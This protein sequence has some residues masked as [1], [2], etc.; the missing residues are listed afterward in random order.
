MIHLKGILTLLALAIIALGTT[1]YNE[2]NETV[3]GQISQVQTYVISERATAHILYGD[4]RGGGHKHG[5]GQP[6]KSEFPASWNEDKIIGTIQS[7]AA[8]DNL[9]WRRQDN[10]YWVTERNIDGIR[11]RV[12]QNKARN[13]VITAYPVNVERN[14]CPTRAGAPANDNINP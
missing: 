10:G 11:I 4:N 2:T 14:P 9:K 1:I 3:S 8:N 7:I 5:V 13:D 12:V 6:C